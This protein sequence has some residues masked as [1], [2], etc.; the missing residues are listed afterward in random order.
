MPLSSFSLTGLDLGKA[1]SNLSYL[2]GMS[3]FWS[4]MFEDS[5][6][7][8]L[9]LEAT[10]YQ[11]SDVYSKFL[12]LTS[13]LSLENIQSTIGYQT[14][15]L[16]VSDIDAV[17]G[18]TN[19][20]YISDKILSSRYI[21]NRPFL[22]TSTLEEGVHYNI[23]PDGT[24]LSL[25]SDISK[26]GFPSRGLAS[27]AKQYALWVA[28][29]Q[30]DEQL[31]SDY[32]AKL[33]QVTPEV[34]SDNFKNFVYGLYYLYI[35]G[36]DLD[37]IRKGLN[38]AL[39]IPLARGVETVLDIRKY[40]DTDQWLVSTDTNSYLIPY[41]LAP[42]VI[43]GEVLSLSQE[44]AFW[45]EV[46]DYINDGEWWINLQIPPSILPYIPDGKDNRYASVGSYAD[47]VMRTYLSKHS[48]LVN[49]KVA[50]FKNIQ[51]F[52]QISSIINR[53][54]PTHTTPIYIWS[55]PIPDEVLT[56]SESSLSQRRDKPACES[57]SVPVHRFSRGSS[58]P[59]FR[60]CGNFIRCNISTEV[61]ELIGYISPISSYPMP[62]DGGFV[63]GFV[64]V[65]KQLRTETDVELGWL[66]AT[67]N[68][69]SEVRINRD[70]M[71]FS[72]NAIHTD[73]SGQ[74][75]IPYSQATYA[76]EN[77]RAVPLYA[78]TRTELQA[79]LNLINFTMPASDSFT[80]LKPVTS[81]GSVNSESINYTSLNSTYNIDF[82]SALVA[83]FS[84]LFVR[85]G[86]PYLGPFMPK[87]GYT[88]YT[89]LVTDLKRTDYLLVVRVYE[90]TY[91]V[92]WITSNDSDIIP[93]FFVLE[94][95]DTLVISI[96]A[97]M[98]RGLAASDCPAYMV[99]G[100]NDALNYSTGGGTNTSAINESIQD[101][102][103]TVTYTDN[104]NT[105]VPLNRAGSTLIL[106]KEVV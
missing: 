11:C 35:N 84:T 90:D 2:Y 68:R 19:T 52:E 7:I 102:G 60:G 58:S 59:I 27:G 72:R 73:I 106:R 20:F 81:D 98:M 54:K 30:I 56:L 62:V 99:R 67:F 69:F 18:T 78:T 1:D 45:I 66:N 40:L 80:V 38:L 21:S 103:I 93:N 50:D 83:N 4:V 24:Q 36:P 31:V 22:P 104:V 17:P 76:N 94:D 65:N 49:V 9:L 14:K 41:G 82:F 44:L 29:A 79:R 53:I 89:P 5:E 85:I 97:P 3:D 48:F 6:K 70:K 95:S 92:Y 101:T 43:V 10:S 12:Q 37:K 46:K 77:L 57:L 16:L 91:G 33:I 28:D 71:V 26:I 34:S 42:T 86:T 105:A 8:N 55:V 87:P 61:G 75:Y 88:T 47:Y 15:L 100:A 32:Y 13:T 63:R 74:G 25:Y 51:Y 23:S 64:D 39:G 96:T